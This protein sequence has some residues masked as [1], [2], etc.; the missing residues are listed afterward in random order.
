MPTTR[1]TNRRAGGAG[2]DSAQRARLALSVLSA[3]LLLLLVW[4][5]SS[6]SLHRPAQAR[7][8]ADSVENVA[9]RALVAGPGHPAMRWAKLDD[10][11]GTMFA[12]Y[13]TVSW[14]PLWLDAGRP[15]A[16]ARAVMLTLIDAASYGFVPAD[17]DAGRLAAMATYL[18][19]P[20][21]RAAF[22]V[23][24]TANVARF[25]R[26][27][28]DGRIEPRDAHAS[29]K[30]PRTLLD[31]ERAV[32]GLTT[33]ENIA[34]DIASYEPP[35]VHYVL[36]KQS[37]ARLR[38]LAAES[39]LTRLPLL[40]EGK[41][42]RQDDAWFGTPQLGRLLSALGDAPASAML[43]AND[44]TGAPD[45]LLLGA[46]VIE[47]LRRFQQRTGLEADGVL[48]RG[49]YAMLTRPV[50]EK[51]RS[52]ELTLERLRWLP[53]SFDAPPLIVNIPAF[54]LY[55]FAND[56][57]DEEELLRMDVVVGSAFDTRTPVFSDTLTTIAFSPYWDVPSSITRQEI[58]PKA[59]R[60]AAYLARNHYEVVR[61]DRDDAPV[62]GTGAEAVA[63]L[64]AGRARLRQTP[65]AHNALGRVKF[66]FP[67]S[68]NVYMHDTPTQSAFERARRDVSHGCIRLSDPVA[69]V[70]LLLA[71]DS[72]WT[73][74]RIAEAMA[75]T[76]PTYVRLRTPRPV[77]L[78]Y[79][80]AMT[81]QD[82]ETRFYPDIYGFDDELARRL[83]AGFPYRRE[84]V[85]DRVD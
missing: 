39:M 63:E 19:S 31:A 24:M 4:R 2:G 14:A 51:V 65:G 40:P 36:V 47:A 42:L 41:V 50:T 25:L 53:H 72:T 35:F 64:A 8:D 67:N 1:S 61:G 52:L 58:L 49:T 10:V 32:R 76:R 13:D 60:D 84:I 80:T 56:R 66:L 69:L 21:H 70:R 37:L 3:L 59:R 20:Q 73:D 48:G 79:A 5:E 12:L 77:F 71:S 29:L 43:T 6:A 17:Y 57:D 22:D 33:S 85:V 46:T 68:F 81:T 38:A 44:S 62:L 83:A 9:R 18:K 28:H 74:E 82:G 27:V 23:A 78:M 34:A 45:S 7:A 15:T 54:R 11:R 26:A 16:Q 55:A 30:I 75:Q